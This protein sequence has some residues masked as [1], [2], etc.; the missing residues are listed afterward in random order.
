MCGLS[1]DEAFIDHTYL[2]FSGFADTANRRWSDELVEGIG[3]DGGKL[4]RIVRP[5]DKM[6]GLTAEMAP[7]CGLLSGTPIVAG[8]GDTAG[9]TF[10]AGVVRSGLM[11]DVAGTASILACAVDVFAPDTKYKTIMFAPSVVDG[12]YTP[13]AYINGGGL[14]IKW[15]CDDVM[16]GKYT[17][18]QLDDLAAAVPPGSENL[19][20]L[21][22]FS[23]RVCPNDTMTRGSYINLNWNHKTGHLFRAILEGI[24][25]E[26][27]VYSDIIHELAPDQK[28]ERV[29][30]VGGGSKSKL[31]TQIKADALGTPFSL[32][33]K[34]DT[35][36]LACCAITGYGVGLY[37]SLAE[38][39]ASPA[40]SITVP[41][42]D[43]Y[44]VYDER[45]KIYSGI[46][47][48]LHGTYEK[49]LAL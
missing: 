16:E 31:F 45:K 35:A 25:Y 33:R 5:W 40:E 42:P 26:Y 48:A 23:G 47:D 14:C 10:G 19:I 34:V 36:A 18:R 28:Y 11:V 1:G 30:G 20:F 44:E 43:L 32:N 17:L 9:S 15:F 4:P 46:F 41:N 27:G 2:H 21:P 24:A 39:V 29:I 12:L 8:C 3:I 6:G 7:R 13:M 49:L 22:H 37:G 38:L